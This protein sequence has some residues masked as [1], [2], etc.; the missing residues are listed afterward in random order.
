[1]HLYYLNMLHHNYLMLSLYF[2]SLLLV[3]VSSLFHHMFDLMHLLSHYSNYIYLSSMLLSYSLLF[4]HSIYSSLYQKVGI[5]HYMFMHLL[6]LLY[7]FTLLYL[8]LMVHLFH[9]SDLIH[10]MSLLLD[11]L[12]LLYLPLLS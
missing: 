8:Y 1:M 10:Y 6:H 12:V 3:P 7:Y 9:G 2:T 4:H 5:L 11:Y